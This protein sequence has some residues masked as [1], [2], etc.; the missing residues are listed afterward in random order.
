[1]TNA[2]VFFL[3]VSSFAGNIVSRKGPLM[4]LA[5][6]ALAGVFATAMAVAPSLAQ[7]AKVAPISATDPKI[8]RSSDKPSIIAN[9]D[10]EYSHDLNWDLALRWSK[11]H[12]AIVVTV[13][14]DPEW[15]M[16]GEQ[17]A[18][19]LDEIIKPYGVPTNYFLRSGKGHTQFGFFVGGKPLLSWTSGVD[20][21]GLLGE[22]IKSAVRE[23]NENVRRGVFPG[24]L[25]QGPGIAAAPGAS[26]FLKPGNER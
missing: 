13:S 16:T 9:E 19:K 14:M 5:Q 1:M 18:A 7:E 21:S 2:D 26:S 24:P 11:T 20:S 15:K 17:V 8:T 12:P 4:S 6:R 23:Y 10:S 3:N 22:I 25:G